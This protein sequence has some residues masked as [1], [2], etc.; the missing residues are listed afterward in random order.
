MITTK[1]LSVRIPVELAERIERLSSDGKTKTAVTT[2]ILSR[3]LNQMQEEE[4]AAGFALLG[5]SEM[6]DMHFPTGAQLKAMR[7]AD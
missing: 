5:D 6:Q 1:L 4:M 3:G 7:F 2:E